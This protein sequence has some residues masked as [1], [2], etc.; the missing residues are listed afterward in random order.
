MNDNTNILQSPDLVSHNTLSKFVFILKT[1]IKWQ[2]LLLIGLV[3]V[4]T[5]PKS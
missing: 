1:Q 4:L 5:G 2:T 3:G